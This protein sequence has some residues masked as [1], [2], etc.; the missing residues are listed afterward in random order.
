MSAKSICLC[1][2]V[3][4]GAFLILVLLLAD[5][6]LTA[7]VAP[8]PATPELS[9]S[10]NQEFEPVSSQGWPLV[11]DLEVY[12]PSVG[13]GNGNLIPILLNLPTGSWSDAVHLVI[14]DS[15]GNVQTWLV[16]LVVRPT[17][18]QA[19]IVL[20]AQM[21]G[22]LAWTV[23]P[24]NTASIA[25]GSY[26]AVA[27]L[28]A[29]STTAQGAFNGIVTSNPVT[30][31]IQ[32]EPSPMPVSLQEQ[33][34]TLLAAYDVLQGN[35]SQATADLNTLLT[36][37]PNS[38]VG[39]MYLGD[40]QNLQGQTSAARQSYDQAVSAFAAANPT[41][42][43]PATWLFDRQAGARA[44]LIS[45]SG[46]VGTPQVAVSL[47]AQGL[48]SP[49]VYY[50]DLQLTNR[51][52]GVAELASLTQFSYQTV[53]GTGQ[54]TYD[55]TLSPQVP[56]GAYSL[57]P[58]ASA[59]ARI[60]LDVPASVSQ[61]SISISGTSQ[62]S[63]G[64]Q[65]AFSG[66]PTI[67]V[68]SIGAANPL[69]V[70]AG[71]VTQV[72]GQA[73]PALNNVTYSGFVNGDTPASLSGTL[74]C[75]TTAAQSS[76][77]GVYPISCSG[78]TSPNYTITYVPGTLTII[79]APLTVTANGVT[80]QYG[81]AIALSGASYSG[82]A[83]GD[84]PA[85]LGGTLT[86]TSPATQASP[87]GTYPITCS[88]LTSTN[89]TITFIQGS[90]TVVPAPLTITA[91]NALRQYGV[92]NPPLNSVTASGFLNGDSLTSLSGTLV[93]TTSA[94]LSSPAGAYPITCLGL[95]STNYSITF[96]NG[97]LTIAGDV[98]TVTANNATRAY[99]SANPMFTATFA[100]FANGDTVASLSGSLA[101]TTA[102]TPASSVSGGPYPINCS[103]LT[104]LNYAINFL[105]GMLTITPA[106]LTVAASTAT[107]PYGANNP[108][109]TG[110]FTGLL[111]SDPVTATFATAATPAS[112]VGAYPI[113]PTVIGAPNVLSNYTAVLI[114]GMLT[115][116]PETTSLSLT[117]SPASIV[118]GQS[119]TATIT[120][121]GPDMV[122]PMDPSVLLPITVTSSAVSDILS[123]NGVCTPVPSTAPGVAICTV[124]LTSV[125]PNGRTLNVSFAG[126][127]ALIASSGTADLIV[128]A[129]LLSKP[130]CIPSDF[131]NV[132]VGGGNTIWFNSIFKVRD[133][134]KQLIH[135][136]FFQS[137]AQFQYK[138]ASGNL[139]T[140]NQPLPDAH[141]TIN[142]NVGI[143]STTFDSV[144]NVWT[145]T[146][147]FDVDDNAFLTG[148]PWLVPAGGIPGDVEPVTVC[149]TFASDVT[150]IDIGWRW[151]A[152]AYSSFGSDDNVLGV[153]PMD[154]DRDNPSTNRDLAGTPEN[155]KQFVIPGARGKGGKN[156]IGSY[157]G[158]AVIE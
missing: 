54:V 68:N 156:F 108:A 42:T 37:Q 63:V 107:R 140:V 139:M 16:S 6:P 105:P 123:N 122:I 88:G 151:A 55:T 115:V 48:Q 155:Y 143:A 95:S 83:N 8:A 23:P 106:P 30:I 81:Q 124:S 136:S 72:Y 36:N 64:T 133:A 40:L 99:G 22:A 19:S 157:S 76:P 91:G 3:S 17:G 46:I 96:L 71:N 79:P 117:L 18:T 147:P 111:N 59:T 62:D 66:S 73:T 47:S 93:C 74:N 129:P 60:Y 131:R 126:S 138:D 57:A 84:T 100:G 26:E 128:T 10:I 53:S 35:N 87:A 158:S 142:P 80:V 2:R 102:A 11:F 12:H 132:A 38:I 56:F 97:T 148:T 44:S 14:R 31:T 28:D 4:T 152:A 69:T 119:T 27:I 78:L 127:V 41:P 45:Q 134:T 29:S 144:N 67:T 137:S 82:F 77:V 114:N 34:Y 101:C 65:Y 70:T 13:Q 125:E 7:Q 9:L 154:S 25:A 120:L 52:S 92:A 75:T 50:F 89:Y 85:S 33:K 58:N 103:G 145:T 1:A 51:G 130:V 39:M 153:K 104:S 15:L 24:A 118:V 86:C 121:T 141:I 135:I 98:L 112:P 32:S 150:N 110:T 90:L 21:E 49:G 116:S 5:I 109:F 94:T 113:V 20:D 146:I 149:G 43:E 61:F